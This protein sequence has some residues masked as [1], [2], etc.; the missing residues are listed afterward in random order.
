MRHMRVGYDANRAPVSRTYVRSSDGAEIASS[1]A[2]LNGRGQWVT[3]TTA[4]SDKQFGYDALAR[5]TDVRDTVAGQCTWRAYEYNDRAGR[6]AMHTSVTGSSI[7][8]DPDDPSSPSV[9]TVGYSY[10]SA[11]RLVSDTG[12]GAEDWVYDPLGRIT[13]APVRGSPGTTVSNAYYATD[14][15]TSQ[16]IP[17]V[18]RQ[19]W[20]L[21]PLHRFSS[22]VNEAWTVGGDGTPGW[23]EAVTKVNHYD[24]DSDS[25]AWIVEDA[26]LPS[27]VTRYVDGLDGSMAMQTG[28]TGGRVLQLIDLHGDVMTTLPIADGQTTADFTGLAHRAADEYGNP[29]DLTTGAPVIT[30]G[31]APDAGD[32]YGWHGGAQRSADA[33]AGVLLM[34]VRLYDPGTG[35]FW[36][37]DSVP[38]GNAT[39]YDY[40]SAD[41]VKCSDL[42][43]KWGLGDFLDAVAKVGEAVATVVP[44]PIGAAVGAISAG[45]Y[46]ARGNYEKAAL[47]T[48]T[49]AATLVGGGL[50][51]RVGIKGLKE[52]RA[53]RSA[54][55]AMP[56]KRLQHNFSKHKSDWGMSGNWNKKAG[57]EFEA[58]LRGHVSSFG[59]IRRSGQYRGQG[60]DL[61]IGVFSRNAVIVDRSGTLTA[62]FKLSRKQYWAGMRKRNVW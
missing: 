21:D 16:T 4:A 58:R 14:L 41:P 34:G 26:S 53:I 31:S 8:A 3:H 39:P 50:A 24:S 48:V 60:A 17:G 42:T 18:A 7:C 2:V 6:T 57:L 46:A 59:T 28:T 9:A 10:D 20:S 11:D 56:T 13:G 47:V 25:P 49:A 35:R 12:T 40:C 1:T 22:Y 55:I 27:E 45:A 19:T 5:L 62:A 37:P 32:R 33:L 61:H 44:G 51:V 15:I 29:T 54:S 23:Q 52:S 38:G 43:G 30:D 36:S